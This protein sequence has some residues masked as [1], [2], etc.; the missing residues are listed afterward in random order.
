MLYQIN[1]PLM[2]L[3][4]S[5]ITHSFMYT[6]YVFL[7][8]LMIEDKEVNSIYLTSSSM[9]ATIHICFIKWQKYNINFSF[10]YV[11]AG[12]FKWFSGVTAIPSL[13]NTLQDLVLRGYIWYREIHTKS[14]I[15]L[16]HASG[17][18]LVM[19]LVSL[20]MGSW[21]ELFF[22]TETRKYLLEIK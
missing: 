18:F 14:V 12:Y 17:F 13:Q 10:Y 21:V 5:S 16:A 4:V 1:V 19:L 8:F 22:K 15:C 11:V 2:Y 20:S 3:E 6:F 7:W 9:T